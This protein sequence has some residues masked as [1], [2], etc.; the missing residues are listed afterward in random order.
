M[1]NFYSLFRF[2]STLVKLSIFVL[3]FFFRFAFCSVLQFIDNKTFSKWFI[4]FA[5][6][7]KNNK[8]GIVL[9]YLPH[10]LCCL[11][12]LPTFK[13]NLCNSRT[14]LHTYHLS[15]KKSLSI[16]LVFEKTLFFCFFLRYWSWILRGHS[17]ISIASISINNFRIMN[18]FLLA[19]N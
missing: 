14:R 5:E 15:H 13:V 8:V 12:I 4:L 9:I 1:N 10:K 16:F 3:S 6:R 18:S 2:W 17:S 11:L 7:C 19:I